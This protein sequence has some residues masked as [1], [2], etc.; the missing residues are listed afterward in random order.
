[1]IGK[2]PR[3]EWPLWVHSLWVFALL[4]AIYGCS[5]YHESKIY[6]R[7]TGARTTW[8]DALW[9]ELRVQDSPQ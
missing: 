6:N 2:R 1:M 9:V 3:D 8:W 4:A 5:E 7:L